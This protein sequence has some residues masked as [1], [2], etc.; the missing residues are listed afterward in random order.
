VPLGLNVRD[1]EIGQATIVEGT[2]DSAC[3]PVRPVLC[4]NPAALFPQRA[5]QVEFP[6]PVYPPRLVIK[7]S[8]KSFHRHTHNTNHATGTGGF[9]C[10][11]CARMSFCCLPNNWRREEPILEYV[12][13]VHSPKVKNNKQG[14]PSM[15]TSW[16]AFWLYF[17]HP[18]FVKRA[19]KA[20]LISFFHTHPLPSPPSTPQPFAE[21]YTQAFERLYLA[22]KIRRDSAIRILKMWNFLSCL[23][24]ADVT[25]GVA[26]HV[27]QRFD[28]SP[29][30]MDEPVRM[31]Q[32]PPPHVR[33]VLS[34]LFH[35]PFV[36]ATR[37]YWQ[38]DE[39]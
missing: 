13:T 16:L 3:S 31:L 18:H 8:H 1:L 22:N 28:V 30:E 23:A 4:S 6:N 29:L 11:R 20:R 12:L 38:G 19:S 10:S 2:I 17:L 27:R 21:M 32:D 39:E 33:Y 9:P 34:P 7:L 5:Y 36:F 35:R 14:Q 15:T 37:V 26:D 25:L 24:G